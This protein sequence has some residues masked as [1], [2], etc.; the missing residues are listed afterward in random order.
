MKYAEYQRLVFL[1]EQIIGLYKQTMNMRFLNGWWKKVTESGK[2]WIFAA[3]FYN[4]TI[5]K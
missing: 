3:E 1:D 2:E 4:F 5:G